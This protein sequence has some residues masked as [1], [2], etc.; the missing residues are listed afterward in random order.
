[1]PMSRHAAHPTPAGPSAGTALAV[2]ETLTV[3]A[4][5][6]VPSGS[7]TSSRRRATSTDGATYVTTACP[8]R[9]SLSIGH[10]TE[11]RPAARKD[12]ENPSCRSCELSFAVPRWNPSPESQAGPKVAFPPQPEPQ[13]RLR[14]RPVRS[15][16][17]RGLAH[18]GG[19]S[20]PPDDDPRGAHSSASVTLAP[21]SSNTARRTWTSRGNRSRASVT[22]RPGPTLRAGGS[23]AP[24]RWAS[25][26]R[27]YRPSGNPSMRASPCSSNAISERSISSPSVHSADSGRSS[28]QSRAHVSA[29]APVS[30]SIARTSRTELAVAIS[31]RAM[32]SIVGGA[33]P[34]GE[35]AIRRRRSRDAA[36]RPCGLAAVRFSTAGVG[37]REGRKSHTAAMA[38]PANAS[39]EDLASVRTSRRD[40]M[41]G[42]NAPRRVWFTSAV[43]GCRCGARRPHAMHGTSTLPAWPGGPRRS[44]DFSPA[45][46]VRGGWG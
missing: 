9:S 17:S 24:F 14:C 21:E 10:C 39:A 38:A 13:R 36:E 22:V 26:S 37:S 41:R 5:G 18:D 27:R 32:F 11:L 40:A 29:G 20:T 8:T 3:E 23:S 43:G 12:H 35:G 42:M 1:M 28:L 46:R 25:Y 31:A 15:R 6:V 30:A 2:A 7:T 4:S 44:D 16:R 33:S 19:R 45:P 34:D